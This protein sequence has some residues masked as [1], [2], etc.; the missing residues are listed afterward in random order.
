MLSFFMKLWTYILVVKFW[1]LIIL[2]FQLS[3]ELNTQYL[4]FSMIF[5][6]SQFWIRLL[7]L[8]RQYKHYLVIVYIRNLILYLNKNYMNITIGKLVYSVTMI[9]GGLVVS[10]KFTDTCPV[11]N[12]FL[13]KFLLHDSTLWPS[14]QNFPK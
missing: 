12:H 9:P 11:E 5:P 1:K 10:L 14:T 8:I 7:Q 4:Y 13:S 3:V 6:R 2:N